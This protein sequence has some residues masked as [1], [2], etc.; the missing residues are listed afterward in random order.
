MIIHIIFA[1]QIRT[2]FIEIFFLNLLQ[3]VSRFMNMK[4]KLSH[5]LLYH[6]SKS[7]GSA[8]ILRNTGRSAVTIKSGGVRQLPTIH[9]LTGVASSKN[10]IR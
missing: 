2:S 3:R 9:L 5:L 4:I 1:A 7:A 8:R 6:L 10:N